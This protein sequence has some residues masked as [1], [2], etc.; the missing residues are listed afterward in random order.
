ML[1]QWTEQKLRGELLDER[2]SADSDDVDDFF[3]MKIDVVLKVTKKGE[4]ESKSK[5]FVQR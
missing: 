1:P 3:V 5:E 4:R 2:E